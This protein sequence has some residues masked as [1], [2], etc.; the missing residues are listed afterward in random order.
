MVSNCLSP[1]M[2][3]CSFK[4]PGFGGERERGVGSVPGELIKTA[5][6]R[7]LIILCPF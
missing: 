2:L 4:S 5:G 1:K 3:N 6:A 7:Y